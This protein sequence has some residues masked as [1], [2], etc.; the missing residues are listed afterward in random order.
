MLGKDLNSVSS[1]FKDFL[2]VQEPFSQKGF[3]CLGL[4]FWVF[5]G[6]DSRGSAQA[7]WKLE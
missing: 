7:Q 4:E 6:P 2:A 3:G 5:S 1:G